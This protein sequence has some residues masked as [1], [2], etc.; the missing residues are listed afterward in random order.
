M[1][2]EL[3][4]IGSFSVS[5]FGVMLVF[6]FLASYLQLRWGMRKL[7]IGDEEDASAL[8]FAA[9]VGGIVGAKVYYAILFKDWHLLFDRSGLVWYG[10]FI[11]GA[12]GVL[13]T[14]RSRRLPAW[15][16]AD[17]AAPALALGYGIGRIGCFLVGDD[18]GRPTDLP[19]GMA[20]PVGLPETTAGNL[21]E[22]FHVAIPDSIPDST[23]LRVHPTQL[24]ETAMAL[25]IWGVAMWMFRRR[26]QPGRPG[27]PGRP[28]AIALTVLALLAV[29]R[30][31]VEIL[32]AKDDRFFGPLTLAQVISIAVFAL[33]G[34][35]AWLRRGRVAAKA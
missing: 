33:I 20:F 5:P 17:V 22:M 21:R 28:G 9:G 7:G 30:F 31:L 25:I 34:V 2:R 13:W 27:R 6:A 24:Y 1:I 11:L 15:P 12:I 16:M 3:F 23:L 26:E 14:L 18:Y 4:H 29:E 10:G 32:R 8:V 35:I 19:W